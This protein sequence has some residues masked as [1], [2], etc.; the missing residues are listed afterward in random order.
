MIN[1]SNGS[2]AFQNTPAKQYVTQSYLSQWLERLSYFSVL[3]VIPTMAMG[4]TA[5]V[6]P[7]D[8]VDPT[9]RAATV[10]GPLPRRQNSRPWDGT[11]N[12][13]YLVPHKRGSVDLVAAFTGADD[14][15]GA[16]ITKGLYTATTPYTDTGN[17][18]GANNTVGLL[19]YYYY[20]NFPMSGPD[21]IYSFTITS[22]GANPE[23]RLTPTTPAHDPA[24]YV[25]DGRSGGGCPAGTQRFASNWWVL[26]DRGGP[27]TAEVLDKNGVEYLPLGAPLHLFVD[28]RTNSQAGAG[29]Y[30]LRLQDVVI[31]TP[32]QKLDFTGD[33]KADMSLYRPSDGIWYVARSSGGVSGVQFGQLGDKI[34]PADYDG[35]GKTDQAV[36]RPSTGQWFIL[37]SSTGLTSVTTWGQSTDIPTPGDYDGDGRADIAIFR[38]SDGRWW[39]QRTTDGI[40]VSQWGQNGDVPALGDYD[41][42]GKQDLAV[43]RPSNGVWYLNR[44]RLGVKGVQ[45]GLS[46]DKIAPADFNGDDVTDFVVFRQSEGRWYILD[47]YG[48]YSYRFGAPGDIPVPANYDEYSGDEFAIFRPSNGTWWI[49]VNGVRVVQF[50]QSGDMPAAAAYGN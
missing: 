30:T 7:G 50:G 1:E 17:T 20:Y 47:V 18:T 25:L 39:T 28:S 6:R 19:Q 41:G 40:L 16:A 29:G 24:I 3:G 48:S 33:L 13:D 11:F 42:D 14:C 36:F 26:E 4:Q 2:E 49:D 38:P 27:G 9:A 23:I 44:S 34:V 31:G 22:T 37:N 5:D 46:T 32:R 35:D 15:P 21:L 8:E 43:F 45:W 10:R 12:P